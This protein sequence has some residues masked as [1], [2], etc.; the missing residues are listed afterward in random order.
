VASVAAVLLFAGIPVITH[1]DMLD[2]QLG[3]GMSGAD[4]SSLQMFLARDSSIYPEGLVTGYFGPLTE[5]AVSNFQNHNGIDP[6]GRVGPVT[7][8]V[9]NFRITGSIVDSTQ[10]FDGPRLIY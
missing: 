3:I 8:P 9:L 1:A 6:I 2:R 4:V 7:L 5:A 10:I